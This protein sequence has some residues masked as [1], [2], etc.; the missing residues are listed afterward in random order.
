MFKEA[1]N[2]SHTDMLVKKDFTTSYNSF[3]C[4]LLLE[5]PKLLIDTN[6]FSI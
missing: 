4:F 3:S 2:L 5:N 1:Y 6:K